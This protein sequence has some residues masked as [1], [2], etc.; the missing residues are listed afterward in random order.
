[1]KS[2]HGERIKIFY[3]IT[4]DLKAPFND[5]V[6]CDE[7]IHCECKTFERFGAL[8]RDLEKYSAADI[9]VGL[10]NINSWFWH[11]FE[12]N[13][14]IRNVPPSPYLKFDSTMAETGESLKN[15]YGLIKSFRYYDGVATTH[16]NATVRLYYRDKE[17]SKSAF[18]P[19]KPHS[20]YIRSAVYVASA[21]HRNNSRNHLV[22]ALEKYYRVDSLGKCHI[23]P[24]RHDTNLI[25]ESLTGPIPPKVE[26]LSHYLF[27]LAFENTVE[28]GYVTEKV[29]DGL[30]AGSN[31]LCELNLI[32]ILLL[33]FDQALCLYTM[34][35]R[36]VA[37]S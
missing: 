35:T 19:T 28:E 12:A 25:N 8:R 31:F 36:R 30:S 16:P 15:N 7:G 11:S 2:Y 6:P 5:V 23:T 27:Y 33:F 24:R 3:F 26:A 32:I 37:D 14:S 9:S 22:R 4:K 20:S 18:A 21:C 34:V 13:Y 17:L 1:M 10:Y 29:F